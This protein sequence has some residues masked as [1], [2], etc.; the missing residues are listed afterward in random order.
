MDNVVL[1]T[2]NV[3]KRS[4]IN[5]SSAEYYS[6]RLESPVPLIYNKESNRC[7]SA[8]LWCDLLMYM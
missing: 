4:E 3:I 1:L 7:V 5:N 2:A 6:V 8:A